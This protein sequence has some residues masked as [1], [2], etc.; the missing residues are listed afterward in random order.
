M[1]TAEEQDARLYTG[2]A[3]EIPD[4]MLPESHYRLCFRREHHDWRL[5]DER[6]PWTDSTA[7]I[8]VA[9]Y[10]G[11]VNI[12]W[13][14]HG[15]HIFHDGKVYMDENNIAHFI[16]PEVADPEVADLEVA[17]KAPQAGNEA[18]SGG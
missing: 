12:N 14:D 10:E 18:P 5:R 16:D 9:G 3:A 17:E 8:H 1:T 11:D 15:S 6:K 7:L 13:L 4:T 2:A